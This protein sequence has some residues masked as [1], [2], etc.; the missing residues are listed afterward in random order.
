MKIY[1]GLI[2]NKIDI[3]EYC[4]KFLKKDKIIYIPSGDNNRAHYFT[5]PIYLTLKFIYVFVNNVYYEYDDTL[6]LCI[7]TINSTVNYCKDF[8]MTFN[9]INNIENINNLNSIHN[10]LSIKYGKFEEEVPEQLMVFKY[11]K[12]NEKILEIGGNIGRNSLVIAYLLKNYNKKENINDNILIN[13]YKYDKITNNF[14]LIDVENENNTKINNNVNEM[15]NLVV[16]ESDTSIAEQLIENRD[17]NNLKFYIENSALSKQKLIQK[18]WDSE[19][20]DELLEGY[21]WINIISWENL[22]KK[23]NID[24]DTLILDCEG[25]FYYI[26]KEMPEILTNIKLIIMENDYYDI[27]KKK[28]VD[29]ILIENNFYKIYSEGGGWGSCAS[30]FYEIWKKD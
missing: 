5:D 24:F 23:Y 15:L 12:G 17:T 1:Y 20:S 10:K 21:Q 18:G 29:K 30:F 14:I 9:I 4:N 28:Y 25:A 11:I 27:S 3:T 2:N 7:N 8:N 26:L 16:L 22:N 19:P 13:K 6:Y